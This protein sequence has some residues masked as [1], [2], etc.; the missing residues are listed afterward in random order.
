MSTWQPISTAPKDGRWLLV[1]WLGEAHRVEAM[2]YLPESN[3]WMWW[4]GDCALDPPTH[5]QPLPAPPEAT[6]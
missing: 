6:P 1:T 5:W 4:E 3:D 2:K